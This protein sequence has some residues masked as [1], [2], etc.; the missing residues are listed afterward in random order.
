MLINNLFIYL[1]IYFVFNSF[2]N[3]IFAM[4]KN[5]FMVITHCV[6]E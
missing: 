2:M 4:V 5:N 6:L 3:D 1:F